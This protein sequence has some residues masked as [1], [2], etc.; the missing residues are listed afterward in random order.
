VL[1]LGLFIPSYLANWF[2]LAASLI[3]GG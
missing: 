2:R 1:M 3:A